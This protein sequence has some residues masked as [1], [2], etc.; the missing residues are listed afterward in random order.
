[1]IHKE[2]TSEGEFIAGEAFCHILNGRMDSKTCQSG[3]G[4]GTKLGTKAE[5]LCLFV[6]LI[7]IYFY[8]SKV[9]LLC[10]VKTLVYSK[11]I[12]CIYMCVRVYVCVCVCM[13]VQSR[14]S[15]CDPVDC[16]LPGFSVLGISQA[17]ILEWIAISYSRGLTW[18]R[19]QSHISCLAGRFFTAEPLG[20]STYIYRYIYVYIYIF[21][22]LFPL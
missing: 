12:Q 1:M 21:Q 16:N 20:K 14:P 17:R 5:V 7:F 4:G 19:D 2:V 8:W 9:G 3:G 15:L 6:F 22:I 10:C 11:L 18:P 13:C